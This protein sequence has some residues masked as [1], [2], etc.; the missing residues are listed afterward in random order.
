M[1]ARRKNMEEEFYCRRV[2]SPAKQA[3]RRL[4]CL[5]SRL[6]PKG[7]EPKAAPPTIAILPARPH[8]TSDAIADPPASPG[9]S[10]TFPGAVEGAEAVNK[11]STQHKIGPNR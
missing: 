8:A 7:I 11:A 4:M 9:S 2:S 10:C 5:A 3:E 1:W 6:L